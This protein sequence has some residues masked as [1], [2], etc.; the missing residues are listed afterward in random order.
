M[1]DPRT[2]VRDGRHIA[3]LWTGVLLAPIAVLANLE[4]A[5]LTVRGSCVHANLLPLHLVHAAFLLIAL[6]G[7]FVA[8]REWQADGRVWPDDEGGPVSRSRFMAGVG[9]SGSALFSLVIIAQWIPTF[10]LH[11]CQ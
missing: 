6:A 2:E 1:T 4:V 9:L 5:Y 8:W 11:P 7:G 3:A 10:T